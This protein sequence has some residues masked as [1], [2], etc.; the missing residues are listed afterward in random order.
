MEKKPTRR[1]SSMFPAELGK[2]I[3]PLTKPVLKEHGL[4]G[5]RIMAEWSNIV[6]A[7]LAERCMPERLT[8]PQG[9][10]TDGTLAIAAQNGFAP[11]LQ[12]MQPVLLERLASYFGY[13]AV[14]R[15]NISH[16]Y[17]PTAPK[18]P[19]PQKKTKA[20][21]EDCIGLAA[22]VDDPDLRAA[23]ESFAKSLAGK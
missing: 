12:Q 9:K 18:K 8:F 10:K 22:Q 19:A 11:Y 21:S 1:R 3:E 20:I 6:G 16:T 23:L 17:V 4:A 15:I 14:V 7:E 2:F 13:K 5:S